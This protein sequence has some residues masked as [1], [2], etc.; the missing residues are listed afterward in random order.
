MQLLLIVGSVIFTQ[1]KCVDGCFRRQLITINS[2]RCRAVRTKSR[3]VPK[4]VIPPVVP[5]FGIKIS[6]RVS[7][8]I[9]FFVKPFVP[10]IVP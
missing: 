2:I 10:I 4:I 1:E 6:V 8:S 5:R 7:L 3:V 9:R